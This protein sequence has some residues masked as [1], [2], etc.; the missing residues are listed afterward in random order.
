ML[1]LSTLGLLQEHP[2]HGY[3]LKQQLELFMSGCISVNFGAIYPLLKRLEAQ[4]LIETFIEEVGNAGPSRKVYAITQKGRN[5]WREKMLE[6]PHES[7]V[8]TRSR[9]MIKFFFFSHLQLDEQI[10]L[11][12]QRLLACRSR[13]EQFESQN[14]VA[15]CSDRYQALAWQRHLANLR[16]EIDWLQEQ[17]QQHQ[18]G[19]N[20]PESQVS[21]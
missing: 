10:Y 2:L 7:W 3:R 19:I 4:G 16:S 17:L 13:L 5:R 20:E 9:F 6:H 11:I 8:N 15:T 21:S 18:S 14:R 12:E 1:E